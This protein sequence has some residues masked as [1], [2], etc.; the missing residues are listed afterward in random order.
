[1]VEIPTMLNSGNNKRIKTNK[2][3]LPIIVS[4][5]GCQ[6]GEWFYTSP[7]YYQPA[8]EKLLEPE[9]LDCSEAEIYF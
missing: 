6:R 1:M 4:Q 8:T 9:N 7:L 2:Q 5:S 3:N